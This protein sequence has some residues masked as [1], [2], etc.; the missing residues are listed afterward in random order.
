M[1]ST[2]QKAASRLQ[3]YWAHRKKVFGPEK[4]FLPLTQDGALRDDHAALRIGLHQM[5]PLPDSSNRVMMLYEP[6]RINLKAF[7]RDAF[8]SV[9]YMILYI[10]YFFIPQFSHLFQIF[11]S[12]PFG[13]CSNLPSK[14]V[15]S[16]VGSSSL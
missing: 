3:Q 11:R 14:A 15:T 5:L 2:Q 8:V 10:Y 16:A 6:K 12:A 7:R 4:F 13:T 1:Q 9:L